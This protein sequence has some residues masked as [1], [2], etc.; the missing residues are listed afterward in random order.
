MNN[1][2]L[3][4]TNQFIN[5]V[6]KYNE[7]VLESQRRKSHFKNF[8]E[9]KQRDYDK[10]QKIEQSRSVISMPQMNKNKLV[11]VD[12]PLYTNKVDCGHKQQIKKKPER[13]YKERVTMVNIDSRHRDTSLYEYQNHYKISLPRTFS[14]IKSIQFKSSEFVNTQNTIRALP[15]SKAN[16]K[17]HWYVKDENFTDA[18]GNALPEDQSV[19]DREN[20]QVGINKYVA[21]IPTGSY[22]ASTLAS[23]IQH[24]MN[25]IR[26]SRTLIN[27]DLTT[28][29]I[30]PYNNFEVLID[31]I[32][33]EVSFDSFESSLLSNPFS[34]D[35]STN[36]IN[37]THT[38][39]G[40]SSGTK[41]RIM[42]ATKLGGIPK[43]YINT[44]HVITVGNTNAYSF[45]VS[46]VTATSTASLG[47]G[48]TVEI[49]KE[50]P[51]K[52]LFS[53]S[54][55]IGTTVGF[56]ATDTDYSGIHRN[57]ISKSSINIDHS[58]PTN[59]MTFLLLVK[60]S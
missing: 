16:N 15:T 22:T 50:V 4:Y 31:D 7:N 52:L 60:L 24:E 57:N 55:S 45:S 1:D 18:S 51:V 21:T 44:D 23:T 34:V 42:N 17:I 43:Q 30:T 26:R 59:P 29:K 27:S 14:N 56:N 8:I 48:D 2:D 47:G 6:S 53:E 3:L 33:N 11:M 49:K 40:Y 20:N 41:V 32:T 54:N 35:V 46:G 10:E 13:Y 37:V 19:L 28:S 58:L 9:Q 25:D 39:H 36:I 5:P 12:D 38:G